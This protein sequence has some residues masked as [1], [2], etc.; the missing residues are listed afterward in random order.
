[1]TPILGEGTGFEIGSVGGKL[2]RGGG[3]TLQNHLNIVK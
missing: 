2:R 1:M 3:R